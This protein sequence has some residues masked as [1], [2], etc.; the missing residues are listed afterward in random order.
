FPSSI[1]AYVIGEPGAPLTSDD[2]WHVSLTSPIDV[3]TVP[4]AM[5]G[6]AVRT[7]A[8]PSPAPV[9][10]LPEAARVTVYDVLG[11]RVLALDAEAGPL[12][13]PSL[14]A[15]RY[16]WRAFGPSPGARGSLTVVR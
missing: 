7:L 2:A 6:L 14:P 3:P 5:R 1:T 9:L 11:R 10:M 8:N 15:G 13:L 12:A 16:L 4:L